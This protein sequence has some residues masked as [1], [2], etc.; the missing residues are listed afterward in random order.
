MS[1]AQVSQWHQENIKLIKDKKP[2]PLTSLQ[3]KKA[4]DG[5]GRPKEPTRPELPGSSSRVDASVVSEDDIKKLV[6]GTAFKNVGE[7]LLRAFIR[8]YGAEYVFGVLDVL[9]ESYKKSG[10][11]IKDPVAILVSKLFRGINPP[12]DF[13]PYHERIEKERKVKEEAQLR[14]AVEVNKQKAIDD[15]YKYKAAKFDAL[16]EHEQEIWLNQA[17]SELPPVLRNFR[18]AVRSTAIELCNRGP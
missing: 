3:P 1:P 16:P 11:S 2:T 14:R 4:P 13:V 12:S 17:K 15:N 10:N 7:Q 6:S 18:Y 5:E 9:I 8:K